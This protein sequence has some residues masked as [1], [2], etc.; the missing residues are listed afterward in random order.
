MAPT[1]EAGQH[2]RTALALAAYD[3]SGRVT[4]IRI[5]RRYE[6]LRTRPLVISYASRSIDP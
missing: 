4:P 6:R 1:T 2:P 5:S 3:T